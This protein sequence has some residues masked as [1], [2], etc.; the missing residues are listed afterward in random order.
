VDPSPRAE[1]V[2]TVDDPCDARKMGIGWA[3]DGHRGVHTGSI[4]DY[5]AFATVGMIIVS[6]ALLL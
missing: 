2:R 6:C 4:N 3:S 5:A 1:A